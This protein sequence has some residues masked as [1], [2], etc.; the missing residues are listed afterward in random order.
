LKKPKNTSHDE[1]SLYENQKKN[2]FFNLSEWR[3]FAVK[4]EKSDFLQIKYQMAMIF[5][6]RRGE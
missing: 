4:P 5:G 2:I 1:A 3:W 6:K